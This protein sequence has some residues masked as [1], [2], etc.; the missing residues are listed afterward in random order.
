MR[1]ASLAALL[2]ALIICHGT[3]VSSAP[4]NFAA[5]AQDAAI[6]LG[7][8]KLVSELPPELPR[9]VL[10]LAYDGQ[11]LWASVY[12][13]HGRYVTLDPVSLEW[14]ISDDR[15]AN[16]VV[17]AVAGS[18]DSPGG[19]CFV[20][21]KLWVAGSYGDSFGAIDT[22]DWNVEKVFRGK[23]RKNERASQSYASMA[24]DG[25]NL[26]IAWHLFRYDLPQSQTQLLLKIDPATGKVIEHFPAPPGLQR[27]ETHAL[28][29]DGWR[30]WH[31]KG[32]TLSAI[33]GGTGRIIEQYKLKQLKRPSGMAWDGQAL[34]IAE[35][36]GKIWRLPL[37]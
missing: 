18:F 29:W 28:T 6:N 36:D 16:A 30:L 15:K 4:N 13:T 10:G 35:F 14:T 7:E 21:G 1:N 20:D 17:G 37:Y 3:G 19:L 25:T 27:D 5:P 33:D 34:W 26:W 32:D 23:Q 31:A 22:Q 8:L 24:Y 11:K 9:R 2:G 12:H